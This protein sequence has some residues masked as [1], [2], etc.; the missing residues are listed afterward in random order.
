MI[1]VSFFFFEIFTGYNSINSF[2]KNILPIRVP[3][4]EESSFTD[5]EHFG[6]RESLSCKL[7]VQMDPND[8]SKP[9]QV[10]HVPHLNHKDAQLADQAIKVINGITFK[11]L[12]KEKVEFVFRHFIKFCARK[13]TFHKIQHW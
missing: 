5:R 12:S 4:H 7:S 11:G 8:P 1:F 10:T 9:L 2:F 6:V 3:K 13:S